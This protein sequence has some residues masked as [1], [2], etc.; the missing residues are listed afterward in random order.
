MKPL[1]VREE[2]LTMPRETWSMDLP[3]TSVLR[4]AAKMPCHFLLAGLVAMVSLLA[5]VMM[6]AW[7]IVKVTPSSSAPAGDW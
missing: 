2:P 3:T 7:L 5:S 1:G 4:P 6:P